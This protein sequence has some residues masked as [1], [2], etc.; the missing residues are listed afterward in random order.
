MD[1]APKDN[2]GW[3]SYIA[4]VRSRLPTEAFPLFPTPS[5][6]AICRSIDHTLLAESATEAQV[7]SLCAE[8]EQYAFASVCVRLRHV[9]VAAQ[10]LK[11]A[12]VSSDGGQVGVACVIG[13]PSGMETTA[14]KEAEARRAVELGASELDMVMR[15]PLLREGR[16]QEVYEDVRAVRSA[17]PH[18]TLLKVILETSQLSEDEVVAGSVVAVA[19]G[20]DYVKT[21]TGFKG[22]GAT[23]ASVELMRAVVDAMGRGC[24]V[25]ASGGVRSADDCV[26]MLRAGAERIGASS[27][28][29]I[30][31]QMRDG[32]TA[33]GHSSVSGT[34]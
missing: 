16:Y 23:V 12:R 14:D 26:K 10:D 7:H 28:V 21:S 34:Y 2:A 24:Q 15:Y 8:A 19:A 9:A 32:E 30:A 6:E 4:S 1:T 11:D 33:Q 25:K 31:R 18:P 29:A 22:H 17:A 13:F 20:A 27:G 5:L 3:P